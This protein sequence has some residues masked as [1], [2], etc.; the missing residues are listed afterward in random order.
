[1]TDNVIDST[2]TPQRSAR[3]LRLLTRALPLVALVVACSQPGYSTNI[4]VPN[5]NFTN[6]ANNGSVVAAFL[7]PM[8]RPLSARDP[9]VGP[10][11]R[12]SAFWHHPY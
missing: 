8:V 5:G 3:G 1:M 10:G 6:A 7:L 9:G 12:F 2:S 4:I 11:T